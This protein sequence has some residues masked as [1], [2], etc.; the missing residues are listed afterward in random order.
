M[1]R[2]IS[3]LVDLRNYLLPT[4]T[5]SHTIH[6]SSIHAPSLGHQKN[7]MPQPISEP[8]NSPSPGDII[9]ANYLNTLQQLALNVKAL[10]ETT[11]PTEMA[12][13]AGIVYTLQYFADN[14]KA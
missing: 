13:R 3:T 2:V 7:T 12:Y 8:E 9:A 14:V 1:A 5:T 11:D 4:T 6:T 10:P